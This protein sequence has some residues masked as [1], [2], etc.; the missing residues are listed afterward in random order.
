MEGSALILNFIMVQN[1]C[2]KSFKCMGKDVL[3]EWLSRERQ[4]RSEENKKMLNALKSFPVKLI[5]GG[6]FQLHLANVLSSA[7]IHSQL[8]VLPSRVCWFLVFKTLLPRLSFALNRK[9]TSLSLLYGL[10]NASCS[11]HFVTVY[12]RHYNCIVLLY[13]I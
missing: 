8:Q 13:C 5:Q 3:L 6:G 11:I 4:H 1:S 7:G 9:L 10:F 2:S 12:G